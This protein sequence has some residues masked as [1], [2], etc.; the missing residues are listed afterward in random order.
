MRFCF[1]VFGGQLHFYLFAG[2]QQPVISIF[3]IGLL[4]GIL[5]SE[6]LVQLLF[7]LH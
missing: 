2:G 1:N 3:F 5:V 4:I 6:L 7:N